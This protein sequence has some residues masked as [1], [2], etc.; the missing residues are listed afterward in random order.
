MEKGI[1]TESNKGKMP[2]EFAVLK[3]YDDEGDDNDDDY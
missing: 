1:L 2:E 3:E